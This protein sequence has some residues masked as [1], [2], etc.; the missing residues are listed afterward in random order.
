MLLDLLKQN[1]TLL[2]HNVAFMHFYSYAYNA[3]LLKC[4]YHDSNITQN[5]V[6]R[7]RDVY[8]E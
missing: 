3:L 6:S 7:M 2:L 5:A 8:G 4:T 1:F